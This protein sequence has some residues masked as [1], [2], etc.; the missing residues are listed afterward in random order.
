MERKAECL[1]TEMMVVSVQG[2]QQRTGKADKRPNA[3]VE[4]DEDEADERE[5]RRDA[6]LEI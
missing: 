4:N 5:Q 1:R 2:R 6:D 3:D